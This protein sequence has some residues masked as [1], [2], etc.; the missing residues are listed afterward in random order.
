[1]ILF[2]CYIT[3]QINCYAKHSQISYPPLLITVDHEGGRVQRF[4]K[5][6]TRLP[7]MG[8]LGN[9]YDQQPR[10]ALQLAEACGYVMAAELL[11]VGIDLSFAPVLDID[12]GISSVIG[13]RAFH[14]QPNVIIELAAAVMNGMGKAGMAA[15]GKHFPGHGSVNLD[16]HLAMPVDQRSFDDIAKDDL[17]PYARLIQSGLHA[18]MPAHILFPEVDDKPVGFSSIWLRKILHEQLNFSGVIFSDDLK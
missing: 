16:S 15:V 13:D 1:M 5:E 9:Y 8:A 3:A 11:S 12:K 2:A 14:R 7:S 4:Q 18:V 10:A 6:F 17:V